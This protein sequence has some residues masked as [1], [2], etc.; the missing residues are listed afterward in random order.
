MFWDGIHAKFCKWGPSSAFFLFFFV[1]W[2]AYLLVFVWCVCVCYTHF[3]RTLW[4][5]G[6]LSRNSRISIRLWMYLREHKHKRIIHYPANLLSQGMMVAA[7][8]VHTL[9][10]LEP[11]SISSSF[12]RWSKTETQRERE[13]ERERHSV[14]E[15]L[16]AFLPHPQTPQTR[17]LTLNTEQNR[18]CLE[19]D[20]CTEYFGK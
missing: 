10:L 11:C 13:R 20:R 5:S 6:F 9:N 2:F 7:A 18:F 19:S 16:P 3:S 12:Y 8:P 15:K 1:C 14:T 4:S 17:L